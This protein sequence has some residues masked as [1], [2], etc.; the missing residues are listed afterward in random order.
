MLGVDNVITAEKKRINYKMLPTLS[1]SLTAFL[2]SQTAL[3]QGLP[4][5][6]N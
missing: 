6:C 5:A 2:S 1:D 3:P 4:V